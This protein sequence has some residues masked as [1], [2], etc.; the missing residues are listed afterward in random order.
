MNTLPNNEI[1]RMQTLAGLSPDKH[2]F[3]IFLEQRSHLTL[4]E[5]LFQ[6]NE[7]WKKEQDEAVDYW[8]NLS[9][10]EKNAAVKIAQKLKPDDLNLTKDQFDDKVVNLA[11]NNR[12]VKTPLWKRIVN[13]AI[14]LIIGFNSFAK[15]VI[16]YSREIV[17]HQF[18]NIRISKFIIENNR[19]N[20]IIGLIYSILG[21]TNG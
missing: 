13:G 15:L 8:D 5:I 7:D 20:F 9:D 10:Q 3:E 4:N 19:S 2:K 6:L 11:P 14:A 12:L 17:G 18:F 1:Q 16:R 21:G